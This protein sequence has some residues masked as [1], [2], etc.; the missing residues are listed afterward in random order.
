MKEKVKSKE[1]INIEIEMILNENLFAKKIITKDMYKKVN[2]KLLRM[3]EN[4]N[5]KNI[6]IN[7][8]G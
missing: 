7:N 2:E 5:R 6:L 8:T 1:E 4:L 3:L